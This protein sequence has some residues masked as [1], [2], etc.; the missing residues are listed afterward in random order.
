MRA[1]FVQIE[2]G[3][4]IPCMIGSE[5]WNGWA[6][7]YFTA[8]VALSVINLYGWD[9]VEEGGAIPTTWHAGGMLYGVGAGSWIWSEVERG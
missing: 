5:T 9:S 1:G 4:E 6:L 2:D 7:P 8:E 3:P